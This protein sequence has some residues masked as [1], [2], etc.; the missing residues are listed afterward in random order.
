MINR[1]VS[2]LR[3]TK[4]DPKNCRIPGRIKSWFSNG[5][6]VPFLI[7]EVYFDF[8]ERQNVYS[9]NAP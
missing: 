1:E 8:P 4:F 5:D 7:V 3:F 2:D 9:S 6:H